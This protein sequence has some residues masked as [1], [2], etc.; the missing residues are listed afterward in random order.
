MSKYIGAIFDLDGVLVDTA[1]FH[2]LAWRELADELMI[3]FDYQDNERLKGVSRMESLSIILSLALPGTASFRLFDERERSLLAERKN[4]LYVDMIQNSSNMALL[5]GTRNT[6]QQLRRKGIRIAL[7]SSSKNAPLIIDRL[8]ITEYF[9]VIIDG[10][11]VSKSKPDPEV[12]LL[13]AQKM[14]I[15]P[16]SCIVF[17]D[18]AAGLKAARSAGMFAVGIGLPENLTDAEFVIPGM[19]PDQIISLFD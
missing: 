3:P 4:K 13:A 12:F 1:V 8:G 7:G 6:L 10:R 5:P 16:G 9:D 2:Y 15:D 18:S 14:M 19:Q 11:H 17:E